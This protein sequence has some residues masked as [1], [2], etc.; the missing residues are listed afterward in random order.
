MDAKPDLP[1]RS[2]PGSA[3]AA[4]AERR[5]RRLDAMDL[6]E[7]MQG[8]LMRLFAG[9]PFGA[10]PFGRQLR[11]M[12]QLPA[13]GMPRVD[14]FERNG[15]L[16]VKAELP[17]IKKEDVDLEIESGDLILRAER[18]EEREVKDENWYRMERSYGQLY[19]RLPLPEGVQTDQIRAALTDGV[20]EVTIPKPRVK[21]PQAQKIAITESQGSK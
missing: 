19:R 2:E 5:S 1:A 14:V 6:F 16:V 17:G 18:R 7:E 9:G 11:R 13:A 15:D 12:P 21:E 20:L 10:L 3:P 4:V 8:D